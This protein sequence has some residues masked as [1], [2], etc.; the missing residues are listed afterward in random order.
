MALERIARWP[1]AQ[2][3]GA[4]VDRRWFELCAAGCGCRACADRATGDSEAREAERL[5]A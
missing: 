5:A 2:R 4:R 1:F 3:G